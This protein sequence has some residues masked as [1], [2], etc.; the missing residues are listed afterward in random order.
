MRCTVRGP[1]PNFNLAHLISHIQEG[2]RDLEV[3]R[4]YLVF[5]YSKRQ[6]RTIACFSLMWKGC[7]EIM[8]VSVCREQ[9]QLRGRP[10]L[11]A[12]STLFVSLQ[13][14]KKT[15]FD[16]I[17]SRLER[18]SFSHFQCWNWKKKSHTGLEHVS[19]TT[20]AVSD[21]CLLM[22][23]LSPAE[24]ISVVLCSIFHETC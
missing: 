11:S 23:C 10:A 6:F 9:E 16:F 18:V 8:T 12:S 13:R 15:L 19:D 17:D 14:G 20:A 3:E 7:F 1:P 4:F 2:K 21:T 22:T 24:F 5:N